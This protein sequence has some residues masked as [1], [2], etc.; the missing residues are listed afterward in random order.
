M[1]HRRCRRDVAAARRGARLH[2]NAPQITA[3]PAKKTELLL[4]ETYRHFTN[5]FLLNLLFVTDGV[6]FSDVV[7]ACDGRGIGALGVFLT[8]ALLFSVL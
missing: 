2:V 1:Q 4:S 5:V 3:C 6:D 8:S 7:L